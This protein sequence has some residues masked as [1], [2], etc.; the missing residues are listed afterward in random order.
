ML[1]AAIVII[2]FALIFYSVGI[3]GERIQRTLK[4]WHAVM[5][6]LGLACDTTGTLLMNQI[7]NARR[8]AGEPAAVGDVVMAVSGT[9]AILL[10][11]VHLVWAIVV[12][13]RGRESEKAVF[14]RFSLAVWVIWLVPYIAGAV[15]AMTSAG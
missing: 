1:A 13:A 4:P 5:F 2:T 12:L 9:I 7:A 11:A 14:H 15:V 6:G 8:A 10:M 3:W